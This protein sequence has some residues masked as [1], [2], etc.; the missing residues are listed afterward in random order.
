[1]GQE[2]GETPTLCV[3]CPGIFYD[4]SESGTRF[5][6]SSEGRR[7]PQHSVPVTALGHRD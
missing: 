1:M 7:L 4:L 6:V 2:A 5:Y 3:K